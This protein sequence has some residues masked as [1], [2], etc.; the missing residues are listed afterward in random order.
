MA[1][2][3]VEFH[4]WTTGSSTSTARCE[5]LAKRARA[6]FLQQ[7]LRFSWKNKPYRYRRPG[8]KLALALRRAQLDPGIVPLFYSPEPYMLYI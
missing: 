4:E 3:R 5:V 7:I 8:E 1:P 6:V 2:G